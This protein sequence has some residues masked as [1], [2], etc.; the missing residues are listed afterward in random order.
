VKTG[1]ERISELS[2]QNPKMVFTSISHFINAD[3]LRQC[4]K[5]MDGDK[6]AGVDETTKA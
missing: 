3:L 1:L 6:A 2:E 4:H 5:E